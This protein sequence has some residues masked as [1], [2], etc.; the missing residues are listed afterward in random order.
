MFS[1]IV[2][3]LA[4]LAPRPFSIREV[5]S[6]PIPPG[7][8]RDQ[9]ADQLRQWCNANCEGRFDPL[10]RWTE[11]AIRIGFESPVDAILFRLAH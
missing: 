8:C 2:R 5:V 1:G 7:Q 6:I 11:T 4:P 9:L 3:A 10:E